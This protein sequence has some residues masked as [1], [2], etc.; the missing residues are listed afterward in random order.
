MYV[1]LPV[2]D[3]EVPMLTGTLES[4]G[5][6]ELGLGRGSIVGDDISWAEA[7]IAATNKVKKLLIITSIAIEE[8]YYL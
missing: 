8:E 5:E 7:A 4:V 1:G 2:G 6:Y 3:S